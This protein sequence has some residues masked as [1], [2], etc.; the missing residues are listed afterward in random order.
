MPIQILA[1]SSIRPGSPE[2]EATAETVIIEP[3]LTGLF[4]HELMGS[5]TIGGVQE[6]EGGVT[7]NFHFND[8]FCTDA[9]PNGEKTASF[10]FKALDQIVEVDGKIPL[11][12]PERATLD[13]VFLRQGG[14][15]MELSI[16]KKTDPLTD[17]WEELSKIKII[18]L[19]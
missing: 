6:V 19:Y 4:S 17:N 8:G 5:I 14:P 7:I 10:L 9:W 3:D 2:A 15:S 1:Q 18:M 13:N 11:G 16:M 12:F